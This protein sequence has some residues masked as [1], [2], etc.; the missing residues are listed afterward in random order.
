MPGR[1][2]VAAARF[3]TFIGVFVAGLCLA[4]TGHPPMLSPSVPKRMSGTRSI[5]RRYKHNGALS[6]EP[7]DWPKTLISLQTHNRISDVIQ[8]Q[9]TVLPSSRTAINTA[10]PVGFAGVAPQNPSACGWKAVIES[11]LFEVDGHAHTQEF[12]TPR[13]PSE[14]RASHLRQILAAVIR[15][16]TLQ[17]ALNPAS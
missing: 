1:S 5:E 10:C 16:L 11:L 9:M 12:Y 17:S 3:Q 14:D 2:T 8:N 4:L 13:F 7:I 15:H 6:I